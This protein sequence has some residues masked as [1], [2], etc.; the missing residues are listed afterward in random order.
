VCR[1]WREWL[2][3]A[4]V[5]TVLILYGKMV[6]EQRGGRVRE[7]IGAVSSRRVS[8]PDSFISHHSLVISH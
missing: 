6:V 8:I 7:I 1:D 4:W 3:L 5:L 2:A